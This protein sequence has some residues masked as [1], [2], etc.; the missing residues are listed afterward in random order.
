[1]SE[2]LI[3]EDEAFLARTLADRLL[4]EGYSVRTVPDGEHGLAAALTEP[5]D[6]MI[7]DWM[8]PGRSGPDICQELR[9][10]GFTRP[11]LM[12]TARDQVGDKVL[13]FRLGADDYVTKPF[14]MAEL[15]ARVEALLRRVP[16]SAAA[17]AGVYAFGDVRV[18]LAKGE[19]RRGGQLVRMPAREF[20]LL[21]YLLLHEQQLL[22]RERL[23]R[24]VWG[25][26]SGIFTRTVDVHIALLR[27]RLEPD[28]RHPL[29]ILTV[30]GSGYRFVRQ[31]QAGC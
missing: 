15:V 28:P 19:A 22:S 8:L 6:L 11:V 18:D 10:R 9:A 31:A 25:I 7:L 16:Q 29:H 4:L 1:M 27:R 30:K 21:R 13:S 2:I 26:R 20:Q 3:V 12:L 14:A 17:A 24:E 23:L 5:V